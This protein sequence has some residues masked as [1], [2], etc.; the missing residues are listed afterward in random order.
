MIYDEKIFK[1]RVI[2]FSFFVI[3]SEILNEVGGILF[4]AHKW[5]IQLLRFICSCG[6]ILFLF[7][8]LKGI[9]KTTKELRNSNEKLKNIFDTL[10]VAIWFHDLK[11]NTLLITPGIEKLYGCSLK[12]FYRDHELWKKGHLSP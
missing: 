5:I 11:S 4:P 12:E 7:L 10:D 3:L 6:I 8:L 2:L 9:N 1:Y